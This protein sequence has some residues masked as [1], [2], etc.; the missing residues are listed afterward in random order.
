MSN[1]CLVEKLSH[2]TALSEADTS[3]IAALE[4]EERHYARDTEILAQGDPNEHLFA[5]KKGWLYIYTDLPDGR[6]QIMRVLVPG[7]IV[8]FPDLAFTTCTTNLRAAEDTILCPFPKRK[9]DVIL[10]TSPRMSALLL[11][12]ANRELACMVDMMRVLGRMSAEERLS[13]FLLDIRA[14]LQ[15]T[16]K[17]MTDTFRM[18]LN[19]QEIGDA[20]GLT[21]TYVSKSIR[22]MEDSGL[23]ERQAGTVRL[24]KPDLMAERIGFE[25]RYSTLDTSWFPEVGS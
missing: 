13:F 15:V 14:R 16:N 10:K 8:G 23:I 9:L 3:Y 20:L 17:A 19:Q 1:S 4:G 11:A 24:L 6:R 12:L 5:V 2:Y 18:P 22:R 7:D 21:H 25:D